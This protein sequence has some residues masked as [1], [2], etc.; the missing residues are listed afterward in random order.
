MSTKDDR[1]TTFLHSSLPSAFRRALPNP[2]PVHSDI[3]S[4]H[5]L[6]CLAFFLLPRTMPCRIIC[7]PCYVPIPSQFALP[8]SVYKVLMR[9]NSMPDSVPHLFIPNMIPVGDAQK[10]SE[11]YNSVACIFLSNS[12]VR[13]HVSHAYR[14][15]EMTKERI[16]LILELYVLRALF[17]SRSKICWAGNPCGFL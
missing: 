5:L 8:H 10:S 12:A 7:W 1:T 9:P 3:L 2:N 16:I 6:F 15:I 13:V 11:A 4:S 14:K 17:G